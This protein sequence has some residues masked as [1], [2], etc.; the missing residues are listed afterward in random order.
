MSF[1]TPFT[2]FNV[3]TSSPE[4]G[5][6]AA[7]VFLPITSKAEKSAE[8]LQEIATSLDQ[9]ITVFLSHSDNVT[10]QGLAT[11]DVRWFT[12]TMELLING[13]GLIAVAAALFSS[14][15]NLESFNLPPEMTAIQFQSPTNVTLAAQ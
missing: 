5:N 7:V 13:H 4:G 1:T 3:F 12:S 10:D 2:L 8:T 15:R 11:F 6:P 9:P 14:S